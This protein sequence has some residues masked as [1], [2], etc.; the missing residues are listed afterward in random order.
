MIKKSLHKK[1]LISMLLALLI[2]FLISN[3]VSYKSSSEVIEEQLLKT[4]SMLMESGKDNLVSYIKELHQLSLMWIYDENLIDDLRSESLSINQI[5]NLEYEMKNLLYYN[6]DILRV[7]FHMKKTGKTYY[8]QKNTFFYKN[9]TPD[10]YKNLE[11]EFTNIEIKKINDKSM[12]V[13][14]RKI[15]DMPGNHVLGYLSIYISPNELN[16]IL[17]RLIKDSEKIYLIIGNDGSSFYSPSSSFQDRNFLESIHTRKAKQGLE[18]MK[19]NEEEGFVFFHNDQIEEYS[20]SLIKFVPYSIIS[21]D[22]KEP[23]R[24]MIFIQVL[25]VLILLLFIYFLSIS[26]VNP[27]KRLIKN[28]NSIENGEFTI[29]SKNKRDRQDELG[30]LESR[31]SEMVKHLNQLINKEYRLQMEI[32]TSQLKVLQAQI[33]PHFLYNT[34]Q[35]M[36]TIALKNNLDDLYDRIVSLSSLFRYSMDIKTRFVPL[37]EELSKAE[38]YLYLQKGRFKD[39]LHYETM[40][41]ENALDVF[42]PK[43]ILQPLLENS[44]IH[45]VEKRNRPGTVKVEGFID[46]QHLIINIIDNGTGF[47][48]KK[49]AEIRRKFT[50]KESAVDRDSGIGLLNVLFRLHF[51]YGEEFQWS[52][53]SHLN[54]GSK[55]TLKIPKETEN[56][57]TDY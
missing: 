45:G 3:I 51:E 23:L 2:P 56:E 5:Y 47:T 8:S 39:N 30:V 34:L 18:K 11:N 37:K 50:S 1:L 32:T 35:S 20:F 52:I 54:E 46:N 24:K 16:H 26:I 29:K 57:G 13:V 7:Q 41:N 25:M 36:G 44:I 27:I 43:M 4:N 6:P 33:N 38:E 53:K 55:I 31:F 21:Q 17:N 42:V 48:E 49:I 22:A 10:E 9:D 40:V 28:V 19:L 15:L 12:V 14:H